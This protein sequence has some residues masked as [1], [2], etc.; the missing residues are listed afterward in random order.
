MH[1]LVADTLAEGVEL[2]IAA[3]VQKREHHD[4]VAADQRRADQSLR[5][6]RRL[7]ALEDRR[8][9]AL[10]QLDREQVE[11]AL[12]AVVPHQLRAKSPRLDADDR[13][14][15]RIEG[16]LLAEYLHADHVLLQL[17]AAAGDG[18]FD[19]EGQE[20]F[21]AIRLLEGLARENAIELSQ[22]RPIRACRV[23]DRA[24]ADLR[25]TRPRDRHARHLDWHDTHAV[26]RLARS[27]A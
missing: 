5:R 18:L 19:D 22:D 26:W 17:A 14:G 1:D 20:S 6:R 27:S 4:G 3:V 8:V 24:R 11:A 15:A 13:I 10:R 23:R 9:A 16:V 12:L 25:S 21:E 7:T 2:A